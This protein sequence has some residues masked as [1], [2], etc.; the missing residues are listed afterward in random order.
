MNTGN[1]RLPSADRLVKTDDGIIC[2]WLKI[3]LVHPWKTAMFMVWRRGM[4]LCI[5][6][7]EVPD[8]SPLRT[9]ACF[10]GHKR[11]NPRLTSYFTH[12]YTDISVTNSTVFE[13]C[14]GAGLAYVLNLHYPSLTLYLPRM[15][16]RYRTGSPDWPECTW[17]LK[18]LPEL[19]DKMGGEREHTIASAGRWASSDCGLWEETEEAVFPDLR[20]YILPVMTLSDLCDLQPSNE[21]III[22]AIYI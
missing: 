13:M 6:F 17:P 15:I 16:T 2:E 18:M 3:T 8:K 9:G 12:L 7:R 5:A 21:I 19:G 14:C 1:Q 4:R 20:R 22:I 11:P 10:P